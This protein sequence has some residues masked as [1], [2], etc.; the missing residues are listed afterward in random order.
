[1]SRIRVQAI[2][3]QENHVLFGHGKG[4]HF[5]IGGG[6]EEGETAEQAI[7]RELR[8]EANVSGTILF[9]IN[10]EVFPNHVTFLV[11]IQ[12]QV[13]RLGYDPEETQAEI[14]KKSLAG[15]KFIPLDHT[16]SFTAIDV[17]YF[18]LLMEECRRKGVG[19]AWFGAMNSLIAQRKQK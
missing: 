18:T 3:I 2:I 13:P 14:R 9:P 5:F 19:F 11:D 16:E 17:Q 8:E 1:M 10:G 6:I 4:I 7:V 12:Y 15:I